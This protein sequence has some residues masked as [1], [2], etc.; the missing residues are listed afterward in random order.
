[1]RS[2]VPSSA[3]KRRPRLTK[4]FL[5]KPLSIRP[6]ENQCEVA[7]TGRH[8][9]RMEKCELLVEQPRVDRGVLFEGNG[10]RRE[11][12]EDGLGR[13][14]GDVVEH[15]TVLRLCLEFPRPDGE[16]HFA[17]AICCSH[18]DADATDVLFW[19]EPPSCLRVVV[20]TEE[21]TRRV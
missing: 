21:L 13:S 3:S 12:L 15:L 9:S 4:V 18:R 20:E 8:E 7:L 1:E 2:K 5:L 19:L 10:G 17:L 11:S 6:V 14:L 16:V